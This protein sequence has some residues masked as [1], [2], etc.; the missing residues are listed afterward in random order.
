MKKPGFFRKTSGKEKAINVESLYAR[1]DDGRIL[2]IR[3]AGDSLDIST[4][5]ETGEILAFEAVKKTTTKVRV[6]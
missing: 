2:E 3:H 6:M 5:T 1:L 4:S